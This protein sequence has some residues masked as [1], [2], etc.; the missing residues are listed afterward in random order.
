[1]DIRHRGEGFT[2]RQQC[3]HKSHEQAHTQVSTHTEGNGVHVRGRQDGYTQKP[4]SHTQMGQVHTRRENRQALLLETVT[5]RAKKGD[6]Y[7]D[8]I[9]PPQGNQYRIPPGEGRREYIHNEGSGV[10][11]QKAGR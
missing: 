8:I 11:T 1:M 10:H 7:T 3:A 5:H 4:S 9:H 6:K 2:D